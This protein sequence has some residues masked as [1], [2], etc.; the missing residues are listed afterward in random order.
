MNTG[1]CVLTVCFPVGSLRT[2][3]FVSKLHIHC[4]RKEYIMDTL[5]A[6]ETFFTSEDTAAREEALC[7]QDL[8]RCGECLARSASDLEG[9]S[10]TGEEAANVQWARCAQCRSHTVDWYRR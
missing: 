5:F 10:L 6:N 8:A 1:Y 2:S 7:I 4:V 3:A 9:Q